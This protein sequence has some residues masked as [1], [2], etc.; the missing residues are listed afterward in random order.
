[1]TDVTLTL[2]LDEARALVDEVE[3]SLRRQTLD[4]LCNGG[5]VPRSAPFALLRR[6]L[7]EASPI[8]AAEER[9]RRLRAV[10]LRAET[11]QTAAGRLGLSVRAYRAECKL[12]GIETP[13]ERARRERG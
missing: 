5:A 1:M 6:H 13:A 2:S 12:L 7:I 4:A 9:E 8:L 11:T 10:S 3:A